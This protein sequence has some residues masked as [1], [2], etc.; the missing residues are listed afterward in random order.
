MGGG[1]ILLYCSLNSL[2]RISTV[3]HS[4]SVNK[5]NSSFSNLTDVCPIKNVYWYKTSYICEL[6]HEFNITI[7][8]LTIR[9]RYFVELLPVPYFSFFNMYVYGKWSKIMENLFFFSFFIFFFITISCTHQ[10]ISNWSW[11]AIFNLYS[12]CKCIHLARD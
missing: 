6:V 11:Y 5:K 8:Y 3:Y 7:I 4:V 10:T 12:T 2:I 9:V 1:S